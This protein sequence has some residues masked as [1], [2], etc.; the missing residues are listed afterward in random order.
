MDETVPSTVVTST[1][2]DLAVIAWLD[3]KFHKSTSE[4]TRKAY[5]DTMNQFRALLSSQ[6]L[7][8]DSDP[9]RVAIVAQAYAGYSARGKQVAQAT[10]NQRLAVLSSF[11]VYARRQGEE[12][13]LYLERNRY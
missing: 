12:S 9:S 8:L 1:N 5:T 7:D 2:I 3:A 11:Y 10:Y 6:G 4:K 13:P